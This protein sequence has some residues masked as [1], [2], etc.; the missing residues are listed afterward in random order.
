MITK[1]RPKLR[2]PSAI[3]LAV[4]LWICV[5]PWNFDPEYGR[6]VAIAEQLPLNPPKDNGNNKEKNRLKPGPGG[7]PQMPKAAPPRPDPWPALMQRLDDA[8][9]DD[10][11]DAALSKKAENDLDAVMADIDAEYENLERELATNRKMLD[12]MKADPELYRRQTEFEGKVRGKFKELKD[13]VR[14]VKS[15]DK[16]QRGN[17]KKQL[18]KL[19][20]EAK[21]KRL[22]ELD[23][24]NLPNK[25]ITEKD[26]KKKEPRAGSKQGVLW[27]KKKV[28]I[29]SAD[30]FLNGI[31]AGAAPLERVSYLPTQPPDP[32]DLAP[33]IETEATPDIAALAESMNCNQVDMYNWVHNNI[34]F[35][36]Y[37]GSMKGANETLWQKEGNDMD[38][39]SLLIA[40]YRYCNIPSRYV[41]GVVKVPIED[42]M[43]W[44]GGFTDKN[45]AVDAFAL[46]GIPITRVYSG[47]QLTSIKIE[48]VWVEAWL[49]M[50]RYRGAPDGS[51]YNL[52]KRDKQ[53]NFD[54]PYEAGKM[55]FQ[56]D[57]SFKR[58]D[59]IEP[60]FNVDDVGIDT[61]AIAE[62]ILGD[63]NYNETTGLVSGIDYAAMQQMQTWRPAV[64]NYVANHPEIQRLSDIVGKYRIKSV[65]SS[66]LSNIFEI[67]TV[68]VVERFSEITD[69]YSFMFSFIILNSNISA[70]Y[71]DLD[72][73]YCLE[74][75][76]SSLAA[77]ASKRVT[78][79]YG[80]ASNSDKLFIEN[81]AQQ[82]P[83]PS[84]MPSF[85]KLKPQLA[86]DGVLIKEG[87]SV[88][89]GDKQ[90]GISFI[91]APQRSNSPDFNFDKELIAG[92]Y[93]ALG[94]RNGM[95]SYGYLNKISHSLKDEDD[96]NVYKDDVIGTTF[97]A[98]IA[99]YY[100]NVASANYTSS[101]NLKIH[102][103]PMPS[104][105]YLHTV[106]IL[107]SFLGIPISTSVRS[108]AI[109]IVVSELT[110]S[111][112][113]NKDLEQIAQATQG[114][115]TSLNEGA[116]WDGLNWV[117]NNG[118]SADPIS[119]VHLFKNAIDE[120]HSFYVVTKIN[121]QSALAYL[122][123]KD[124]LVKSEIT[125]AVYAG[126][127]VTI[128]SDNIIRN[129]FNGYGY[130]VLSPLTFSAI[131]RIT[132]DLNGGMMDI[133]NQM[134]FLYDTLTILN[135][136]S[137]IDTI[138]S[139]LE[140]DLGA[141]IY[142]ELTNWDADILLDEANK[143]RLIIQDN[144]FSEDQK[145][146]L[147]MSQLATDF[148]YNVFNGVNTIANFGI[149]IMLQAAV[150]LF[151]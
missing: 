77:L 4:F 103:L 64:E 14:G 102:N 27:R 82:A 15:K 99:E 69:E 113:G 17:G 120:N 19:L 43:N 142:G 118:N 40:M 68:S 112:S 124:K 1:L 138:Y 8:T 91:Y 71:D 44:A 16:K 26:I 115:Y 5:E 143:I 55:W 105:G 39:A 129:N 78:L 63:L 10:N 37:Y 111:K 108:F 24:D 101:L 11:T 87:S 38:Q 131:F 88:G 123:L 104:I 74:E 42:A 61:Q 49:S 93:Y 149:Y 72:T 147:I 51:P 139:V 52:F 130:I 6:S 137:F 13:G 151:A 121:L 140:K 2:L 145:Q 150:I 50:D 70:G 125:N 122:Q 85:L 48:H 60:I 67:K 30:P 75:Y 83:L 32:E 90:K 146:R 106:I 7:V 110:I 23:P 95:P 96:T 34:D 18:R 29:A 132:G 21:P 3:L 25:R 89:N 81:A 41:V 33:T 135:S 47:G 114:F 53:F 128:H 56:L 117:P 80:P 54:N 57:A 79:S 73:P 141:L 59:F 148:T 58:Y 35:V 76:K 20:D 84:K 136:I 36:P 65:Y 126:N 45:A 9:A 134:Y 98:L 94:V 97:N 12:D 116:V 92:S 127:V 107:N 22:V 100:V 144:S 109:D 46:G 119:T 31:L 28:E 66:M 62:D 133:Y 86:V